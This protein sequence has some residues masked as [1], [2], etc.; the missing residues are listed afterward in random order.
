MSDSERGQVSKSAAEVYEEF[1]VPALFREWPPR[2]IA[3]AALGRDSGYW[4]SAAGPAFSLAR[5]R[6]R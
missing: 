3:S 4:T 2:V 1:F 5:W 6:A